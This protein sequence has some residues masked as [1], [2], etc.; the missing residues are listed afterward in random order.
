[1]L[2]YCSTTS[3]H[4]SVPHCC[5]ALPVAAAAAAA[6]AVPPQRLSMCNAACRCLAACCPPLTH[7][8]WGRAAAAARTATAAAARRRLN[9]CCI[10]WGS[11]ARHT[12][13]RP[14]EVLGLGR[15]CCC[16]RLRAWLHCL[17]SLCCR[18]VNVAG[19][20]VRWAV[21]PRTLAFASPPACARAPFLDPP[22]HSCLV[23]PACCC[24]FVPPL[25]VSA[26]SL[27]SYGNSYAY[28]R[29]P[30]VGGGGTAGTASGEARGPTQHKCPRCRKEYVSTINQ[31]RCISSHL[32]GASGLRGAVQGV[33]GGMPG[34][35]AE[36]HVLAQA[37]LTNALAGHR[38]TSAAASTA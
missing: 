2:L 21:H 34:A 15:E 38:C 27:R 26:C 17:A 9:R 11:R 5:R 13:S 8:A 23:T 16:A 7:T 3:Q 24:C 10:A 31:R 12:C 6:N 35:Q 22:S 36:G 30:A 37:Y 1:M 29:D 18:P 28:S 4:L 25:R 33:S 19:C 20:F 14:G 32:G